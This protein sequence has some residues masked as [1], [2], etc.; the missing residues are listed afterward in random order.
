MRVKLECPTNFLDHKELD[1]ILSSRSMTICE[2]DPQ[3]VIVNPGTSEFLDRDYFSEY[4]N[5]RVVGTPSTGTN[6]VDVKDLKRNNV[7]VVC[8][9][10]NKK[11]LEQIHASAEFTWLHIMNLTRKFTNATKA[12]AGWR[13]NTNELFLRS[14]ELH[15]KTI[16]IIG[17]GRIGTKVAKYA[18][19][20]GMKVCFYDPYVEHKRYKKVE[21]LADLDQCDVISI[22]CALTH[23]TFGMIR[24]GLW[25]YIGEKTIVV[26]TS[27]GEVVDEDYIADLVRNNGILYGTD[28]LRNEQNIAQLKKS[29]ILA[30]SKR[31]QSVV[32]TP[33]VAGATKESQ[34]KA[35]LTT[36]DLVKGVIKA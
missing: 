12:T 14:N 29:P 8:L 25:D 22:N 23:E 21:N 13:S 2:E 7:S 35:L 4:K 19:A 36:L 30:L 18:K 9:L 17:L 32:V 1:K 3:A 31:T 16:G 20:F 24:P 6:H 33:H 10:D 5:L 26:N 27:R 11:S 15:G 28:V 34:T